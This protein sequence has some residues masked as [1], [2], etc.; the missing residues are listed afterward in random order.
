MKRKV[1]KTEKS[2]LPDDIIEMIKKYKSKKE[3]ARVKKLFH[4][5][6]KAVN[7]EK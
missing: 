1:K 4:K 6:L 7:A 2:T 3:I 5:A